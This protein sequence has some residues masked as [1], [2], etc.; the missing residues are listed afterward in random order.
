MI[1]KIFDVFEAEGEPADLAYFASLIICVL[2]DKEEAD[3]KKQ[4]K[5]W[6]DKYGSKTFDEIMR[7]ERD[8]EE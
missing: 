5:E 1:L 2:K 7:M 6:L 8:E 3:K 4:V